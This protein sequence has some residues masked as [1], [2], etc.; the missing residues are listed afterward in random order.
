MLW[1]CRLVFSWPELYNKSLPVKSEH[2]CCVFF[3]VSTPA[4]F[5]FGH[6]GV[7]RQTNTQ[8][9][10]K[11]NNSFLDLHKKKKINWFEQSRVCF[12]ANP[13]LAN[14][15]SWIY[16]LGLHTVI[17][18]F[19]PKAPM[20]CFSALS[21]EDAHTQISTDSRE[22]A[23]LTKSP[24]VLEV[25]HHFKTCCTNTKQTHNQTH[26]CTDKERI[27]RNIQICTH[28]VNFHNKHSFLH[29]CVFVLFHQTKQISLQVGIGQI[30][31][32]L[33]LAK[34]LVCHSQKKLL[35]SHLKQRDVTQESAGR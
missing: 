7:K 29:A 20:C 16:L 25:R 4:G 33:R 11:L 15:S 32:I 13:A 19:W 10:Y 31:F 24:P 21:A 12:R 35:C 1:H 8:I 28:W 27:T 3:C 23:S 22:L 2:L 26:T 9:I 17:V 18:I 14:L 5:G 34:Q 30:V 6:S